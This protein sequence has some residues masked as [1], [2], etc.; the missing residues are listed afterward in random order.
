M[1]APFPPS[2]TDAIAAPRPDGRQSPAALAIRR[3]TM[4]VLRT[5]GFAAVPELPLA[6]G[7][8]AD[9]VA[10]DAKGAIWIV[11]I[12]S[13]LDDFR[14]DRKW[15][16]YRMHC[17]RLFFAVD[18]DFPRDVL[19]E[20]VGVILADAYGAQLLREAPEHPLSGAT[21]KSVTLR[22]ARAAAMRLH[23]LV[24]PDCGEVF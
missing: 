18:A 1:T 20:D 22:L 9:L 2:L 13:C 15:P 7:R 19:P 23:G 11:E 8:R 12:K 6:S 14:T 24:D 3:G 17:D 21:R 5:L 10:F 4:R 16:D